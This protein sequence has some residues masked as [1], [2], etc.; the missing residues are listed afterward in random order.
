MYSNKMNVNQVNFLGIKILLQRGTSC[1]VK[2]IFIILKNMVPA[3]N[4]TGDNLCTQNNGNLSLLEVN[5]ISLV[6]LLVKKNN[7]KK[8]YLYI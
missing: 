2:E 1:Y 4:C 5:N 6:V 8:T 7:N 3:I